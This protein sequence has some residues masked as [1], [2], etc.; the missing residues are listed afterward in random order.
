MREHSLEWIAG[1]IDRRV[2]LELY[3]RV[4]RGERT[5]ATACELLLP[6]GGE[7]ETKAW[8][9]GTRQM[10]AKVLLRHVSRSL[11]ALREAGGAEDLA[12]ILDELRGELERRAEE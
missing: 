12:S 10:N 5:L 4:R 7:C 1:E 8:R 11:E 2:T 3:T 6:A 9:S